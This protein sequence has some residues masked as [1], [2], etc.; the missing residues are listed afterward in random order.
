[1]TGENVW[2]DK[3]E[4]RPS[5]GA[6]VAVDGRLLCLD[7]NTGTLTCVSASPDGWKEFGRLELPE[8]SAVTSLD[9]KV[10]THPVVANGKLYLRHHDRLFSFALKGSA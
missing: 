2:Q 5:K 9:G 1:M 4:G 10:W 6:I 3:S 7:E 8:R